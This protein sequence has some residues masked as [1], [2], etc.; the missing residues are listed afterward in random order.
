MRFLFA[1]RPLLST[2]LGICLVLLL[3]APIVRAEPSESRTRRMVVFGNS[4]LHDVGASSHAR[5]ATTLV[6]AAL[7]AEVTGRDDWVGGGGD[8]LNHMDEYLVGPVPDLVLI[9]TA[10]RD[11]DAP[12]EDTVAV[13]QQIVGRISVA[14]GA[15]VVVMGP[16]GTDVG[17]PLERA[18]AS[19]LAG[20]AGFVPVG[21]VFAVL[22][23]HTG[24]DD[25]HPNDLGHDAIARL[26]IAAASQQGVQPTEPLPTPTPTAL[27]RP[28]PTVLPG[29]TRLHMPFS[30]QTKR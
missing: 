29:W 8:L 22:E 17:H 6:A 11:V 10:T 5:G 15:K 16:W 28:V 1:R 27:P 3:L 19:G 12:I 7:G 9:H 26:L 13:A 2:L 25:W 20:R 14:W 21:G 24:G 18:L 23:D 4:I 30:A